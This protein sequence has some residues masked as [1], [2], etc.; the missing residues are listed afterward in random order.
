M[1][2]STEKK[3]KIERSIKVHAIEIIMQNWEKKFDHLKNLQQTNGTARI[4]CNKKYLHRE[5][6]SRLQHKY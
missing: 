3:P 1:I 2:K 6:A 5:N 4:E